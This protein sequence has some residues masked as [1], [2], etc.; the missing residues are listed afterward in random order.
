[1]VHIGIGRNLTLGGCFD[2][3][4]HIDVVLRPDRIWIGDL[5]LTAIVTDT[6]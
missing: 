1:M 4:G 3:S 6:N 5:D 2:A